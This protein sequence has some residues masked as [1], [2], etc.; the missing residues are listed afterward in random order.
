MKAIE[1]DRFPYRRI[2]DVKRRTN[3]TD[4]SISINIDG[5]GQTQVSTG[6]GFM[7]HMLSHLAL[8]G[9][10]DIT[11]IA[12]GDLH[13]DVHHTI[14]DIAI[15]LGQ[16]FD[17][18]WG[19]RSGIQRMASAYAPMDETL[20]FAAVDLS[21]RPYAVIAADW[22]APQVGGIPVTLIPHFFESFTYSSRTTLHAQIIHGRDDHHKAEALFKAF[23]RALDGASQFDPR[24]ASA[25]PSTKGTLSA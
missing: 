21:G 20:A 6:I 2:A 12:T 17:T 22:N 9:L 14:E 24:R 18:A 7:D 23:A 3:E 16:A 11:L 1:S 15:C 5:K 4:I 19:N 10:F 25:I 13:I 8:H